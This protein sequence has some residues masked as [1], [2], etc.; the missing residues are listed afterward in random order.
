MQADVLDLHSGA[1]AR[2]TNTFHFSFAALAPELYAVAH[3]TEAV[4]A[5][6]AQAGQPSACPLLPAILPAS[7]EEAMQYLDGRR[8]LQRGASYSRQL[9]SSLARFFDVPGVECGV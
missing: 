4:L 2:T 8:R 1:E 5:T 7:Y 6:G 9:G 3:G